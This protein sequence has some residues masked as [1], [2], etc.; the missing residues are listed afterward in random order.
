MAGKCG[1]LLLRTLSCSRIDGKSLPP[2]SI[3]RLIASP[4]ASQGDVPGFKS[5]AMVEVA[6]CLMTPRIVVS[7]NG[8]FEACIS[9]K[10]GI[11]CRAS[12]Q[13]GNSSSAKDAGIYQEKERTEIPKFT[14]SGTRLLKAFIGGMR[15]GLR[16]EDSLASSSSRFISFLSYGQG[17]HTNS[18]RVLLRL[19]WKLFSHSCIG[20]AICPMDQIV[21]YWCRNHPYPEQHLKSRLNYREKVKEKKQKVTFL[22]DNGRYRGFGK[23]NGSSKH[24][25]VM[26]ESHDVSQL[27]FNQISLIVIEVQ[28]CQMVKWCMNPGFGNFKLLNIRSQKEERADLEI[29][30]THSITLNSSL[31]SK[32]ICISMRFSS[33]DISG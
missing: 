7:W 6:D 5:L 8:D 19:T 23:P 1:D 15:Y 13:E 17:S 33:E 12:Y 32:S 30:S 16:A 3:K 25:E 21:L 10:W 14:S 18:S 24:I 9:L 27:A 28:F 31:F 2:S 29:S 22:F 20:S 26:I 4:T 11:I